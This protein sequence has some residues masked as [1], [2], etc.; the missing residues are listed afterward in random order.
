LHYFRL[1]A[2]LQDVVRRVRGEAGV[3]TRWSSLPAAEL[4][5]ML[6]VVH[7]AVQFSTRVLEISN[8]IIMAVF[9][10]VWLRPA[11]TKLSDFRRGH[12]HHWNICA[13]R[14]VET[15]AIL[16]GG[17][18]P[19]VILQFLH[20]TDPSW[21]ARLSMDLPLWLRVWGAALAILV[22]A[23]ES[24]RAKAT[25]DSSPR[26]RLL[27]FPDV[28]LNRQLCMVSMLMMSGSPFI[29]LF[30]MGWMLM[31]LVAFAGQERSRASVAILGDQ[32]I[33]VA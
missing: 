25:Q 28:T 13:I 10:V 3:R 27:Q 23:H 32:P 31:A 2:V 7:P 18:A 30:A 29:G 20:D 14:P 6:L 1:M 21:V 19:W 4:I 33:G 11:V 15:A 12:Y 22:V 8:P 17:A 16:I 5:V 26:A 9:V 24:R